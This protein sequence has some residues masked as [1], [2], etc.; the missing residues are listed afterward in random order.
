M[1]FDD[2]RGPGVP[3][4]TAETGSGPGLGGVLVG[5]DEHSLAGGEAVGLHHVRASYLV[6]IG[7]GHVDIGE[8]PGGGGRHP[9][10]CHDL[11]GVGLRGLESRP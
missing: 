5:G 8:D 6:E 9:G 10:P 4:R 2:D 3:E 1:L 7:V 11:F